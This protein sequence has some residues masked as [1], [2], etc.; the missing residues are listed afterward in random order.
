MRVHNRPFDAYQNDFTK[1]YRFLQQDYVHKQD[2]FIWL[3]SRLG[4]WFYGL[5]SERKL[6]PTFFSENAQLWNDNLGELLGFVLSEDGGNIFY[7]FTM[8]RY[9]YLYTEILEWTLLNWQARSPSL[10]TE[11][12]EYQ[13]SALAALTRRGFQSKGEVAVTRQYDVSACAAVPP[14]VLPVGYTIV[15]KQVKPDFPAKAALYKDGFSNTDKVT[16]LDIAAEVYAH[17]SPAYDPY[18]DLSV[19]DE[20]GKH[21]SGCVGFV[22]PQHGVAEIEKVCTR[23]HYRRQGLAE[24][25]IRE[26]F[27]RLSERGIPAAY[28]TGYSGEA[29]SLYEKMG[30]C[31]HKRWYHYEWSGQAG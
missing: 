9:E 2:R 13:D 12:H 28:I 29:N 7:I 4:D 11:V 15:D 10:L 8:Q 18:L 25:V 6:I 5:Y 16:W 31:K 26:C 14:P 30:P 3:F 1:M 21:L 20:Q 19:A 22:D 17:Q 24:A 27:R 23:S